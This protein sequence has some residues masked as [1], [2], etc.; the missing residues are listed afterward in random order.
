M[1]YLGM[2]PTADKRFYC[3]ALREALN[4]FALKCLRK[5][6]NRI[7]WPTVDKF[8]KPYGFVTRQ[9]VS[10][11]FWFFSWAYFSVCLCFFPHWQPL[12][13]QSTEMT[14]NLQFMW[15]L[16]FVLRVN[17]VI[18]ASEHSTFMQMPGGF[19]ILVWAC[20]HNS[21]TSWSLFLLPF[22]HAVFPSWQQ[23]KSGQ[24]EKKTWPRTSSQAPAS[25]QVGLLCGYTTQL[26]SCWCKGGM[27]KRSNF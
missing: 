2:L 15:L 25:V 19:H 26:F 17:S 1:Y 7:V 23:G 20:K 4:L 9:H 5:S 24:G 16:P 14:Y 27:W 3:T 6:W 11:H 22:L 21:V 13:L 18:F 10:I 12:I 8:V